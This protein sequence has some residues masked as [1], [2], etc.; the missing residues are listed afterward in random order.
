MSKLTRRFMLGTMI[1]VLAWSEAQ[2]RLHGGI[3]SGG[4][5]GG[6]N[7]ILTRTITNLGGSSLPAT[8]FWYIGHPFKPTEVPSGSIVTAS[9]TGGTNIP[10]TAIAQKYEADGSLDRS[11]FILDFSGVSLASNA[12]TLLTFA[13]TPGSWSTTT[14]RT[15]SDWEGLI[16]TVQ[17]TNLTTTG[18]SHPDMDKAGTWTAAFD[19]GGTNT[20]EVIGQGPQG[21]YVNVKAALVNTGTTHAYLVA[22]MEY[23]VCQKA[24][25][26]LGPIASRGP[27]IENL[28]L[29]KANAESVV[30]PSQFTY[31]FNW[32]RNGSSQRSQL[33]APNI[34][35]STAKLC[36]YDGQWD[37]NGTD[38]Q[39]GVT[40]DYTLTRKTL[41]IPSF[42]TGISYTGGANCVPNTSVTGINTTTGVFTVGDVTTFIGP[43]NYPVAIGFTAAS[44]PTGLSADP[45]VYWASYVSGTTF[46][47]YDSFAHALAGGST[48]QVV[49]STSGTSVLIRLSCAP[50]TPGCYQQYMPGGS[51]R[52]DISLLSEWGSAYHVGNTP[53]FQRLARVQ[54]YARL[55]IPT[56]VLNDATGK[57][58]NWGNTSISGLGTPM[59]TGVVGSVTGGLNNWTPDNGHW[60]GNVNYSVWLMEGGSVLRDNLLCE[61]NTMNQGSSY[62][63]LRNMVIGGITY[64]TCCCFNQAGEGARYG[65]WDLRLISYAAFAAVNG[66]AEETY[67]RGVMQQNCAE[68][69]AYLT[70]KGG[71]FGALGI[72]QYDDTDYPPR[73][74]NYLATHLVVEGFMQSYMG[75]ATATAAILHGDYV[76]GLNTVATYAA[77]FLVGLYTTSFPA[78]F[79]TS[80][81][82][83]NCLAD[84]STAPPGT[85]VS[86]FAEL[87]LSG[88]AGSN[89][90][91]DFN[92]TS[93]VTFN[94]TS[95]NAPWPVTTG[96]TYRPQN[97]LN[98]ATGGGGPSAPSPFADGTDYVIT[99][100]SGTFG[101]GSASGTFTTA[102]TAGSTVTGVGGWFLPT[103]QGNPS[104]GSVSQYLDDITSGD[105]YLM[106]QVA[107]LAT[108]AI[109]GATG[110][111]T[112]C[113]NAYGRFAGGSSAFNTRCDWAFQSTV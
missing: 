57:V 39:I 62:A 20:I 107:A 101:S 68:W 111:S 10:I 3:A 103:G 95:S 46:K 26:T 91:F 14:S 29:L 82:M 74:L 80:Y 58:P 31:D 16:D 40:Q 67:Y 84:D 73:G 63:A 83:A 48:G 102:L 47:I 64:Y 78:Y 96:D 70:Y 30:N 100:A 38:P 13:I 34:T 89:F 92:G 4:G 108:Q 36:R 109:Y 76:S 104:S 61:G 69:E 113:S 35:G 2:A 88:A 79:A 25:T 106:Y 90:S 32:L 11:E 28:Q 75:L 15:N 21:L 86:S 8:A 33:Q 22:R 97:Y 71:N 12:S 45:A 52:T 41:K 42:I 43:D 59:P 50:Q 60:P 56:S 93:T 87:G 65:A 27:F 94:N 9:I 66:S 6:G 24:D 18:T 98:L 72:I 54:A 1:G 37:W 110:A 105:C 51:A 53:D 17:L 44:M 85:Y 55:S 99:G 81:S 23:L 77:K 19:G 5:G 112:A 7:A 49:P